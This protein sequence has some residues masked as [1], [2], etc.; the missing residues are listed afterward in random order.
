MQINF[1]IE[2]LKDYTA[3]N[4]M[5]LEDV[6]ELSTSIFPCRDSR[7][8]LK[9]KKLNP[10]YIA[11]MFDDN[12]ERFPVGFIIWKIG[13]DNNALMYRI[14]VKEEYRLHGI[15]SS[16]VTFSMMKLPCQNAGCTITIH[17]NVKN[18]VA[19]IF[20][21][22]IGFRMHKIVEKYYSNGDSAEEFIYQT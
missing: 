14:G 18:E 5:L 21:E 19:R 2:S 3:A 8:A 1:F 17:C 10:K 16:L 12:M 13:N 22:K 6:I 15:G 7:V 20:Y 9:S 4:P 11:Y